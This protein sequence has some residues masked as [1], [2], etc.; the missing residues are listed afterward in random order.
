MLWI[1][2]RFVITEKSRITSHPFQFLENKSED[3][4][5]QEGK[6][7]TITASPPQIM[8]LRAEIKARHRNTI[9]SGS[10]FRCDDHRSSS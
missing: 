1:I 3:L 8:N 5:P 10:E 2:N 9:S 4:F 7:R 6:T